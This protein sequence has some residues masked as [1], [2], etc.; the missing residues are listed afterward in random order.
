MTHERYHV[1]GIKEIV[2]VEEHD[3]AKEYREAQME[4]A[5]ARVRQLL[6]DID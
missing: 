1:C 6:P 5:Y 4:G 3:E 2:A